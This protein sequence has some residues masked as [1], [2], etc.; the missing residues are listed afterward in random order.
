MDG[1]AHLSDDFADLSELVEVLRRDLDGPDAVLPTL[2]ITRQAALAGHA[3]IALTSPGA[4]PQ[5]VL[6]NID[7]SAGQQLV[8]LANGVQDW[9]VEELAR[10]GRS[11]VWPQC[12]VHPNTHPLNVELIA[13]QARWLC[14]KSPSYS[15]R[16]GDLPASLSAESAAPPDVPN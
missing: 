16:V 4:S 2:T 9:E 11:A 8:A 3:G 13:G 15:W 10:L 5:V 7:A 6:I 12:A 14:P 1:E